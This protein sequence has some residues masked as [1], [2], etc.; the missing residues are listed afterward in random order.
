MDRNKQPDLRS[1]MAF[2]FAFLTDGFGNPAWQHK[3]QER[4]KLWNSRSSS[5]SS[6][7]SFLLLLLL[8][9]PICQGWWWYAI[10]CTVCCCCVGKL[11]CGISLSLALSSSLPPPPSLFWLLFTFFFLDFS[12]L[13]LGLHEV[14]EL[15]LL[16]VQTLL[17]YVSPFPHDCTSALAW[18]KSSCEQLGMWHCGILANTCPSC[19]PSKRKLTSD[20]KR[21]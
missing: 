7:S 18:R 20:G 15:F 19:L 13:L 1:F 12:H 16:V 4:K 11:V 21:E 14:L 10:I 6:S 8:L 3:H 9:L 2:F 5:F 17:K